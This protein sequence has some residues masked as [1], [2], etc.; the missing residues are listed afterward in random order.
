MSK[1]LDPHGLLPAAIT[2]YASDGAVDT[3]LSELARMV[4]TKSES[5]APLLAEHIVCTPLVHCAAASEISN[6]T[7]LLKYEQQQRTGSFKLR[8]ELSKYLSPLRAEQAQYLSITIEP[9]RSASRCPSSRLS[10]AVSAS[11]P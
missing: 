2:P 10:C 11:R 5:I 1:N 9:I 4:V 6:S 7:F 8:G 3:V